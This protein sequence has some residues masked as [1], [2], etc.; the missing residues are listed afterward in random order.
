MFGHDPDSARRWW[1]SN[2][3]PSITEQHMQQGQ[4]IADALPLF[5]D[6]L[7]SPYLDN[8]RIAHNH[9]VMKEL[10]KGVS[11]IK[12]WRRKW[13]L[14]RIDEMIAYESEMTARGLN[15]AKMILTA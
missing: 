3:R 11:R 10:T 4:P 12:R 2:G 9:W 6:S 1:E 15:A 5:S 7:D 8:A 14:K 13:A